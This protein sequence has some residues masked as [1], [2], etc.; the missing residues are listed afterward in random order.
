MNRPTHSTLTLLT[1]IT[2]LAMPIIAVAAFTPP[3]WLDNDMDL[4]DIHEVLPLQP[5]PEYMSPLENVVVST[6]TPMAFNPVIGEISTIQVSGPS[7]PIG[8][9]TTTSGIASIDVQPGIDATVTDA[10]PID[11]NRTIAPVVSPLDIVSTASPS[12]HEWRP[13]AEYG[14]I[15]YSL[16]E[17]I[18]AG[19]AEGR[20]MSDTENLVYR[21]YTMDLV[22]WASF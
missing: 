10:A 21:L 16:L 13:A 11:G 8:G 7:A 18:D 15:I 14:T 6:V 1:V 4:D 3:E 22:P 17:E 19:K 5:Y 12:V 2:A 9:E 20:D